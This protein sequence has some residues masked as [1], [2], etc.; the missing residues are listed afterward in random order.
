MKLINFFLILFISVACQNTPTKAQDQNKTFVGTLENGS[1]VLTVDKSKMLATYN[2]NLLKVSGIDAKFSELSILTAS[3]KEYFL[4]F[5]GDTY[6]SS[7]TVTA[8]NLELYAANNISCTTSECA[9]EEFGCTPKLS[10]VACRPCSNKGKC[11]KT[12]SSD[13]LI[14]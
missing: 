11:T 4:V 14:D 2:E 9:S 3:D 12:V 7:F 6:I 8:V 10:G 5:K 13:S 1:A